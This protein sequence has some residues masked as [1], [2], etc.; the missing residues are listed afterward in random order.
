MIAMRP[1]PSLD[2]KHAI[3]GRVC[4]G[5]KATALSISVANPSQVQQM[6]LN[7]AEISV[8]AP[9]GSEAGLSCYQCTG[10]FHRSSV[11][12]TR[13]LTLTLTLLFRPVRRCISGWAG[14]AHSG[15]GEISTSVFFGAEAWCR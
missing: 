14:Q 15:G 11:F 7:V 2:G 6:R 13:F 3:F 8:S 12:S 10:D 1:Q 4:R 9:G 5:M